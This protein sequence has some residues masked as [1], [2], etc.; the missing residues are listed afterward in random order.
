[1]YIFEIPEFK[2]LDMGTSIRRYAPPIGTAG[3]AR[4]F[5]SGYKRVPAPPP[6]ITAATDLELEM[7]VEV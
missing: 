6:R 5:V 3:F 4:D 1:M 7:T 2:Q